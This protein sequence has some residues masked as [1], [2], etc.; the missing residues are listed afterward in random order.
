MWYLFF[1]P[2]LLKTTIYH[3]IT[4]IFPSVGGG[5]GFIGYNLHI[6]QQVAAYV[7]YLDAKPRVSLGRVPTA[8]GKQGKW[9]KKIPVR[10]NTGN[11]EI[12]P[13]HKEKTGNFVCLNCKCP[14]A[15]GKGYCDICRENFHFFPEAG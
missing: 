6:Q 11:L 10:K 12:L 1:Q 7:L 8:Q 2:E 13:K 3:S 4:P 14:D 5:G 15:K 9:P